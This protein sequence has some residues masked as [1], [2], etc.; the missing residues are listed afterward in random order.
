MGVAPG[1]S[2]SDTIPGTGWTQA[3]WQTFEAKVRWG[4]QHGLALAQPGEAIAALGRTFVGTAYRPAT[5]EVEGPE[6]LVI[7]LHELDCVTF[8]E[9]VLALTRFIKADGIRMLA[10]PAAARLR[11]EGYLRELR[12]RRGVIDGYPSRLHY[13]SEW[14]AA[15]AA[16]GR[17][18]IITRE[19]GGVVD[20]EPLGFMSAHPEAYRQMAEA[21]VVGA[22]RDMEKRLNGGPK[23]WF[24]PEARIAAA[25]ARIEDGDVIAATSTVAGLDVAHTGFALWKDGKLHLLHAP[26][27]G[28]AVEISEL[29]LAERIQ[30]I[31]TQD[32]IMVARPQP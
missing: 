10:D 16:S 23:R 11:F 28:S 6:R 22:I 17:L 4:F 26:L 12:Y 25:A 32:G 29:P 7:N 19:L 20:P 2:P 9:T 24:L 18:R 13:F 15:N 27:V 31:K 3:D 5:L 8:V 30:S 1:G 14:L 21:G